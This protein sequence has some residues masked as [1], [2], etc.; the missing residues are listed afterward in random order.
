M[1]KTEEAMV[2]TEALS[3][4]YQI[5]NEKIEVLKDVT[6]TIPKAKFIALCGPSGSGKSTLLNIIGAI[7]KPTNGKIVVAG[8]DLTA[9]R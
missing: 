4:T 8:Q 2:Q 3:K 6:L 5:G 7:D 9:Q 1:Q